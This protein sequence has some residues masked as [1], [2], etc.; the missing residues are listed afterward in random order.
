MVRQRV[1][2]LFQK[3]QDAQVHILSNCTFPKEKVSYL[4]S[5]RK[6]KKKKVKPGDPGY[7]VP[8]VISG[9][10]TCVGQNLLFPFIL[11]W[12]SFA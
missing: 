10:M 7:P 8:F 3:I 5:L 12:E 4:L 1:E 2:I 11:S 9:I 6:K